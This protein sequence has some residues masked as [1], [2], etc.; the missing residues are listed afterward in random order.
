VTMHEES[1][2]VVA[3]LSTRNLAAQG[4]LFVTNLLGDYI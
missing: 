3:G 4:S 1:P 2:P